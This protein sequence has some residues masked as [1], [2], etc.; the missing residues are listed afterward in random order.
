MSQGWHLGSPQMLKK[1]KNMRGVKISQ[2][3]DKTWAASESFSDVEEDEK[4]EKST[5]IPESGD[6]IGGI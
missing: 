6:L 5:D 2:C 4:H 3:Q 1:K